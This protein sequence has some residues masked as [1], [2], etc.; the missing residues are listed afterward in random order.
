[1][2]ILVLGHL[3]IDR[4]HGQDG[5]VHQEWGGIANAIGMLG[6][7]AGKSDTVIPVSGVSRADYGPFCTWAGAFAQVDTSGIYATE[8]PTNTVDFYEQE[9]GLRASCAHAIAD[10]IP[11]ER[12]RKFLG[13][14]GILINMVSGSD[15]TLE[16]LDLI[17]MEVRPKSTPIHF[18]YHNLTTGVGENRLRLRRPLPEWRR[19]AFMVSSLQLNEA[20]AAG[21]TVEGMGE[22]Q[23]AGHL[24]TLGTSAVV[25]TRGPRG[26][27]LYVNDRKKVLRR[28]AEPIPAKEAVDPTGL[29]DIFG[30]AFLYKSLGSTDLFGALEF[31]HMA[32]N[33]KASLERSKRWVRASSDE[34]SG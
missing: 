18:D 27:T 3:S 32:A 12:V 6:S 5:S 25:I 15:I 11:F 17:R 20:E 31:A 2:K 29:G 14:D 4:R 30:A 26:A 28:D 33:G 13:V 9:S 24:L 22:E 7:I 23:L 21:L 1:M 16:T 10:A 19:W 34:A 8:A